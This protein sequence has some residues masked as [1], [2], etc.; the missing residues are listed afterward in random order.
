MMRC[1]FTLGFGL[2]SVPFSSLSPIIQF[3]IYMLGKRMG[4]PVFACSSLKT[5]VF[6][7]KDKD[8]LAVNSVHGQI[9]L[10]VNKVSSDDR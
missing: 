3:K 5:A 6:I 9:P 7:T 2:S 1:L 8:T 4:S 10:E